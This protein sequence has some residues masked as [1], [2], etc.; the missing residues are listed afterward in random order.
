MNPIIRN[1]SVELASNLFDANAVIIDTETT[2]LGCDAQ[3]VQLSAVDMQGNV[4]INRMFKPTVDI[5]SEASKITGIT[6]ETVKDEPTFA[7]CWTEKIL[8]VLATHQIFVAY[9]SP[10]DSRML[11]QTCKAF[12]ISCPEM[13]WEDAMRIVSLYRQAPNGK[14]V[15][16]CPFPA[17]KLTVVAK[18]LG[19]EV[20]DAHDA[21]G[22]VK[23]TLAVLQKIAGREN[24]LER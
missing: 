18:E 19:V 20:K 10:F 1:K 4:L 2:G 5:D 14:V 6:M 8:P 13:K 24:T 12:D 16:N 15:S 21:L 3:I 11:E 23:M 17:C 7:E 22:D 9:N